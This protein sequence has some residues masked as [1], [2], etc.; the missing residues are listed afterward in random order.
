MRNA[1]V[2]LVVA[3]CICLWLCGGAGPAE[4]RAQPASSPLPS[5]TAPPDLALPSPTPQPL[6]FNGQIIDLERG[7]VVFST[8]DAFKLSPDATVVDAATR[9]RPRYA[10]EPGVYAV[11]SL[12]QA[13]GLV[14][15]LRVSQHPL[16]VGT[17]IAQVPRQFVVAVSSPQPNPDLVPPRARYTSVLSRSVG[18][19]IT[20]EVPP[21]T[22]FTDDVYMATDTS[23]WNPQAIKMQRLDGRHFRIVLDVQGGTEI[24]YLFTRGTWATVERDRA[25]LQ[26][27]PRDLYV[28]GG[29]SETIDTTVERWADLP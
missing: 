8:G 29:D 23:G 21:D 19:V 1:A 25:G 7:Y 6:L 3:A 28:P 18:V 24:H 20:V 14:T 27:K 22:P 12:A 17:P 11:A 15:E 5:Q 13:S 26:R 16:A 10:I 4:V 2:L 9:A